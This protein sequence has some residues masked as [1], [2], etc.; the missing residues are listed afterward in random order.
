MH[1]CPSHSVTFGELVFGPNR[2]DKKTMMRLYRQ[3]ADTP[4]DT[5]EKGTKK[6]K[7]EWALKNMRYWIFHR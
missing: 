6:I 2:Y 1:S 4:E 5:P 3:A 7:R